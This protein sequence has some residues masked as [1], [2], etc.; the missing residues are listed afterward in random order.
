MSLTDEQLQIIDFATGLDLDNEADMDIFIRLMKPTLAAKDVRRLP[1]KFRNSL[2]KMVADIVEDASELKERDNTVDTLMKFSN[3]SITEEELRGIGP[4][5]R[6]RIHGAFKSYGDTH[7][8]YNNVYIKYMRPDLTLEQIKSLSPMVKDYTRE[9]FQQTVESFGDGTNPAEIMDRLDTVKQGIGQSSA[10]KTLRRFFT[11]AMKNSPV[12]TDL[13][14]YGT[15]AMA[16]AGT[17]AVTQMRSNYEKLMSIAG[18][19]S[20]KTMWE[21][22]GDTVRSYLPTTS[23]R[24]M[25][26]SPQP[27]RVKQKRKR[28]SSNFPESEPMVYGA[29][30]E[31]MQKRRS[32]PFKRARKI[33]KTNHIQETALRS[34]GFTALAMET[35]SLS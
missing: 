21:S 31:E 2:R 13:L 28:I 14:V 35:T 26:E 17:V 27:G 11:H 15:L 4:Q 9:A 24:D 12:E 7:D 25:E 23:T 6:A 33:R 22:L 10:A 19:D 20:G 34:D 30:L 5:E 8:D 16:T 32:H 18:V 3:P 1:P 29:L